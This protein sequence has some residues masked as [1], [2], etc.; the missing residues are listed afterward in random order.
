VKYWQ[1]AA[2]SIGRDYGKDFVR[3]G[4]AFVGGHR[5]VTRMAQVAAGDRV[6]LKKGTSRIVAA[7]EVVVRNGK[8]RGE[9]DKA[10]LRDFDGWDLRGYCF[11]N[12]HVPAKPWPTTGLTRTTIQ[13]VLTRRLREVTD[14]II[15]SVPVHESLDPEPG[16]TRPI[17]DEQI[18]EYLIAQGLRPG[19]AEDLTDTFRRVRLLARYYYGQN[20]VDIREHETRTFLVIPLLL[21]LGWAEQQI[22]IELP[23][24]NVGRADVA[25]FS[26]PFTRSDNKCVL[27]V[28]TKGFNQGLHYAHRQVAGYAKQF[29]TCRV[30]VVS[31]GY[32]YK[33][34]I[35]QD[36]EVF[37]E[38]PTAYLNLL[39]P[40]DRYPLDPDNVQGSLEVLRT[41]LP[42][43]LV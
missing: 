31:N 3:Y 33:T 12:W 1:I 10:W 11:V 20:R 36:G 15:S 2:G 30:I 21:A 8:H 6:L 26:K 32:C 37:A 27:I 19:A 39:N 38:T 13:N 29:P 5:N 4:M 25:C 28:E 14:E 9:N 43:S 41:L 17:P 34:W 23:V 35:R 40:R 16:E 7:G 22:K 24:K 18:V 42:Y